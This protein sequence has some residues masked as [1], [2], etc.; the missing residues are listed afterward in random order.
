M[1]THS[2]LQGWNP[3]FSEG[4]PPPLSEY[5]LFLKQIKKVAPFFLTTIQT[6]ACKL[7]ETLQNEG[8]TFY[9]ILSQLR[10]LSSLVYTFR[11]NSVFTTDTC[12]G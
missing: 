2:F 5:P 3:P 7:Y 9:T 12:L 11:L 1:H 8:V 10:I 6:G 4:T